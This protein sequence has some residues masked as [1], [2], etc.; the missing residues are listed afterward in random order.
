MDRRYYYGHY[1]RSPFGALPA[2]CHLHRHLGAKLITIRRTQVA[3]LDEQRR[4]TRIIRE[5][6]AAEGI[7]KE[8]GMHAVVAIVRVEREQTKG[9]DAVEDIKIGACLIA[10]ISCLE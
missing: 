2:I 6:V 1:E 5:S 4:A 3:R 10:K 7:T 8:D 9:F